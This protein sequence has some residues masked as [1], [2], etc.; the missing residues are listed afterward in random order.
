[1]SKRYTI[2]D[3]RGEYI[4]EVDDL[5]LAEKLLTLTYDLDAYYIDNMTGERYS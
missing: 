5:G 4:D 2:Y 1:M 3:S